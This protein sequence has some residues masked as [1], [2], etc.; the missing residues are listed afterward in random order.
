M[1]TSLSAACAQIGR[2]A[3]QALSAFT[4]SDYSTLTQTDWTSSL[5]VKPA[6]DQT[7]T[8]SRTAASANLGLGIDLTLGTNTLTLSSGG[9]IKQGGAVGNNNDEDGG[10]V[11]DDGGMNGDDDEYDGMEQ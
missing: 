8:A 6:A 7:L 11:L 4:T 5:H 3:A 2:R 1:P 9:L 10:Y